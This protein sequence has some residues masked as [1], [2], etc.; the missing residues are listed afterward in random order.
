VRR[1]LAVILFLF[2]PLLA[3]GLLLRV[4]PT[5][6]DRDALT[7]V[8][9]AARVVLAL[10]SMAAAIGLRDS[11]PYADRLALIVLIASAAFA[12][13]QYFTR[14]LPTSLAPDVAALATGIIVVH[15][16]AWIVALMVRGVRE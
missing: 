10:S 9:F 15:H 11:R 14:A 2:E 4:G 5:L 7:V 6:F 1:A 8:A 3:A 13:F 12:V 16:A